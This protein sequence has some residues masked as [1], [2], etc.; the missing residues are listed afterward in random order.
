MYRKL[1][2]HGGIENQ[3]T[4]LTLEGTSQQ[5]LTLQQVIYLRGGHSLNKYK[6]ESLELFVF[7]MHL[8]KTRHVY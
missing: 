6:R 3:S 8:L 1:N 7:N 5:M 2:F 4:F